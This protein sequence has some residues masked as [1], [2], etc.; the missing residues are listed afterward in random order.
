MQK[1]TANAWLNVICLSIILIG[2]A[3]VG[4]F[5]IFA[6]HQELMASP[7]L[8][9]SRKLGIPWMPSYGLKT[10]TWHLLHGDFKGVVASNPLIIIVLPIV[11]KAGYSAVLA[12]L[13]NV[14]FLLRSQIT[15]L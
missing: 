9:L 4:L 15:V 3:S 8:S 10:A 11:L 12:L 2:F 7:Q 14:K 5:L 13:S 1:Q 6:N